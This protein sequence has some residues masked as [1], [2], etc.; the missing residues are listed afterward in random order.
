MSITSSSIPNYRTTVFEYVNLTVIHGEPTYEYLQL[1]LNQ[2]KANARVVHTSLGGGNHGYLGLILTHEQYNV[3]APNTRFIPSVHP[4]LV[5][6]KVDD[7]MD[8]ASAAGSPYTAQQL[9]NFAYIIINRM[10]K[11][12][13]GIR[14]W[15]RLPAAPK[16]WNTFTTHFATAHR[17]LRE[18]GE[19]SINETPFQTA[20]LVQ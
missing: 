18:S 2:L 11:F 3:I 9:I 6:N 15:N 4:G 7:L 5:F 8:L 12:T 13:T 20:N 14:E 17:E 16:T 1:L 10:G 19:L